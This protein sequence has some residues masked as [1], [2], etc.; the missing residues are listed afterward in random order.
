MRLKWQCGSQGLC[1][2]INPLSPGF[3]GHRLL[4][5]KIIRRLRRGSTQC[6][7]LLQEPAK[8]FTFTL[9]EVD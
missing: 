7:S 4:L 5:A 8:H 3:Y 9:T 2:Y 1:N 6:L